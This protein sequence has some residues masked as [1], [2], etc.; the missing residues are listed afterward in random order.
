MRIDGEFAFPD[1]RAVHWREL[2]SVLRDDDAG[3]ALV[4]TIDGAE[5]RPVRSLFSPEAFA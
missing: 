2:L 5:L 3:H 4:K 1:G